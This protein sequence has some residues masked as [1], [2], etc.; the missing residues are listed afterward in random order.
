MIKMLE[1]NNING[2]IKPV[3][4]KLDESIFIRYNITAFSMLEKYFLRQRP[5]I[6]VLINIISGVCNAISE[7][8]RYLLNPNDLVISAN[9][10]LWDMGRN[11]L[12]LIYIPF[13][14]KDIK[15]QL[16]CF[17]EYIMKIFDYSSTTGTM[18]MHRIYDMI[19]SECFDMGMLKH[20]LGIRSDEAASLTYDNESNYDKNYIRPYECEESADDYEEPVY[21]NFEED[22]NKRSDKLH[23]MLIVINTV[24]IVALFVLH[25]MAG[26]RMHYLVG[27][28]VSLIALAV[29]VLIYV[30]K[31]EKEDDID[32]DKSM[33][34]FK[35][36]AD[37][38]TREY[39]ESYSEI[40]D[41]YTGYGDKNVEEK[42][43]HKNRLSI[44]NKKEYKLVPLNDGMLEPI[45]LNGDIQ[46][47]TIGRGRKDVD[48]RLNKEQI[49]RIHA[50]ITLNED[51]IYIE[52]QN[53]TNGTYINSE[54]LEAFEQKSLSV[55]DIIKLANEDFFVS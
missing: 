2:L 8:E 36:Y 9:Y 43:T 47:I 32:A 3:I 21:I 53:S 18:K 25:F 28:L 44:Q 34:D 39:E 27:A 14:G 5:D 19:V 46:K 51:G 45:T 7:A 29:N 50:S 22:E 23:E 1:G 33:E 37:Q 55:G 12:R 38:I 52:D 4:S 40:E 49:S 11:E 41:R 26:R 42:A 30:L 54:R 10:M 16:K 35:V 17:I 24:I 15:N 20:E 48:Y 31:K 13:Y 6:D